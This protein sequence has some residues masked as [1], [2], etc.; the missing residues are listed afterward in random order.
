MNNEPTAA[1]PQAKRRVCWSTWLVA[2]LATLVM[3]V[4]EIPGRRTGPTTYAHGWPWAYLERDYRRD[5]DFVVAL[6]DI[7]AASQCAELYMQRT[8]ETY[9][10]GDSRRDRENAEVWAEIGWPWTDE[11]KLSPWSWANI[12]RRRWFWCLP[13]LLVAIAVIWAVG[14]LYQ[15]WRSRRPAKLQFSLRTLLLGVALVSVACA[16]YFAWRKELDRE[17]AAKHALEQIHHPSEGIFGPSDPKVRETWSPPAWLPESL[18]KLSGMGERFTRVTDV[19]LHGDYVSDEALAKL[20]DFAYLGRLYVY[21]KKFPEAALDRL[22][23]LS[24]LQTLSLPDV[25]NSDGYVAR[26]ARIKSLVGLEIDCQHLTAAAVDDLKTL[27]RLKFV[28]LGNVSDARL[29]ER[30]NELPAL[31][32]LALEAPRVHRIHLSGC[33]RLREFGTEERAEFGGYHSG[34]CRLES[35]RLESLPALASARLM[36]LDCAAVRLDGLPTLRE[37]EVEGGTLP[38]AELEQFK[39]LPML[40]SLSL[41]YRDAQE[42]AGPLAFQRLGRLRQLIIQDYDPSSLRLEEL[43]TL[44]TL[45]LSGNSSLKALQLGQLPALTRLEMWGSPFVVA[46]DLSGAR[47]LEVLTASDVEWNWEPSRDEDNMFW[48]RS[49]P[50]SIAGLAHL[51]RLEKLNLQWTLLDRG[52]VAD[53]ANLNHLRSLDLSYTSLGNDAVAQLRSL[54]NLAELNL[55]G[56]D[57]DDPAIA[58]LY[59]LPRSLELRL[60]RTAA[61]D[62]A[63]QR[64]RQHRP[65]FNVNWWSRSDAVTKLK[66]SI[67]EVY[68]THSKTIVVP[69]P[70]RIGDNDLPALAAVADRVQWLTLDGM[71]LTDAGMGTIGRL[72]ALQSLELRATHLTDIGLAKLADLRQLQSLDL[73]TTRIEGAGLR[74]LQGLTKLTT[75]DLSDTDVSDDS[76]ASLRLVPHLE[77]LSLAQTHISDTGMMHLEQLPNLRVLDLAGTMV[78]DAGL[79]HLVALKHLE[80]LRLGKCRI[81]GSGLDQLAAL[82]RFWVL[83][84][85]DIPATNDRTIEHIAKLPH[86]FSLACSGEVQLTERGVHLLV[87]MPALTEVGGNFNLVEEQRAQFPPRIRVIDLFRDEQPENSGPF[88]LFVK[89]KPQ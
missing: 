5:P 1:V 17:A 42:D 88:R 24:R 50:R 27:G 41:G 45:V 49:R 37:V 53:I 57:V 86:L 82:P 15:R 47:R 59:D 52:Q 70:A 68:R 65:D 61:T 12:E 54:V 26:L 16:R 30:L 71:H 38:A 25:E 7:T 67:D 81:D 73:G 78:T 44:E 32:G 35:L 63:V 48:R 77:R 40:E 13:D 80:A 4:V 39:R 64:L 66:H 89:Q 84:L 31:E 28:R 18:L 87:N 74:H 22:Q 34:T 23:N 62:A 75:L 55:D 60:E 8:E 33:P 85:R 43:P 76:L 21:G 36:N 3:F 20:G 83:D 14:W 56:D 51:E 29:I 69:E 79:A 10:G 6:N 19:A 72:T 2:L 46:L 58:G 11:Q 9:S